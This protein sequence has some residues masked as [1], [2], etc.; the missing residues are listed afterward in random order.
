MASAYSTFLGCH[1]HYSISPPK[2]SW[3]GEWT[4]SWFRACDSQH[5][6]FHSKPAWVGPGS[7]FCLRTF[8]FCSETFVNYP[9][10]SITNL[11]IRTSLIIQQNVG[12]IHIYNPLIA[13]FHPFFLLLPH[14]FIDSDQIELR[15]HQSDHPSRCAGCLRALSLFP[16]T[17]FFP[18]IS[19]AKPH[20]IFH[21]PGLLLEAITETIT[22][23]SAERHE[24]FRLN[25][26]KLIRCF[27]CSCLDRH[28]PLSGDEGE[29]TA[30]VTFTKA[31]YKHMFTSYAS[32]F[33]YFIN[34]IEPS[35]LLFQNLNHHP[36]L[37]VSMVF[38]CY[39]LHLS[40]F[41]SSRFCT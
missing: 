34:S 31:R 12:A 18:F 7:A 10:N 21:L 3:F 24:F 4:P 28:Y 5:W 40:L 8:P 33:L 6:G 35:D 17:S 27:P 11:S 38:V 32:S 30:I 41:T 26:P 15:G 13:L 9:H 14:S 29:P 36:R 37:T 25:R 22:E 16:D 1:K 19:P 20:S 2:A 23:L 39:H